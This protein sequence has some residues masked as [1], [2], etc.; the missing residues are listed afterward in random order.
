MALCYKPEQ[1]LF[2]FRDSSS[3]FPRLD[4]I[5]DLG[6]A[7]LTSLGRP[8]L[9]LGERIERFILGRSDAVL[10]P[11]DHPPVNRLADFERRAVGAGA[12][13]PRHAIL[14]SVQAIPAPR[15]FIH[16]ARAFRG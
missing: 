10:Q 2:Q 3:L 1:S 4:Q 16:D 15:F 14:R 7:D 9:E 12:Y 11:T 6:S 13:Y 8:H 5:E